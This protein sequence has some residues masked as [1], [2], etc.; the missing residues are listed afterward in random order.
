MI[1]TL[2]AFIIQ[3]AKEKNEKE[4]AVSKRFDK[5]FKIRALDME[6]WE[7]IQRRST[8]PESKERVDGLGMLKRVAIEGCIDPNYKQEEFLNALEVKTPEAALKK[9]LKAGEIVK[10]G[11]AILQYSGFGESVEKAR[12]EA[13]D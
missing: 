9:T 5:K 7:D 4:I 13:Q 6:E 10:L 3:A 11:N 2:Q 8:N 1:S 12:Q